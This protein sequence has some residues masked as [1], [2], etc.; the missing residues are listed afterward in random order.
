MC[1]QERGNTVWS[2]TGLDLARVPLPCSL[3]GGEAS[4][5][6]RVPGARGAGA[7]VR[8]RPRE[9]LT[10]RTPRPVKSADAS[11]WGHHAI[12][13][14]VALRRRTNA[15]GSHVSNFW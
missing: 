9:K 3:G 15:A 6:W 5:Q 10:R 14:A 7:G 4:R 12:G 1:L 8:L 11:H 13:V 2:A